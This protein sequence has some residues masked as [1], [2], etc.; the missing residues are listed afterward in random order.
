MAQPLPFDFVL[1]EL[2]S[3]NPI[4]NR[5]FGSHGLYIDGKIMLILRERDSHQD[6]NGVWIATY[7]EHHES[8]RAELP[9]MRSIRIFGPGESA[10]QN[11]PQESDSFDEDVMTVCKLIRRRDPRIGRVP[12]AKKP[13]AKVMKKKVARKR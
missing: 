9:S 7:P 3:L 8:L 13:K 1:D 2:E 11:I 4:T 6:D 5:M 10:W 12:K